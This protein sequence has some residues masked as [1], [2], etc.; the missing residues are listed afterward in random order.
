MIVLKFVN[1]GRQLADIFIKPLGRMRLQE[2]WAKISVIEI[3]SSMIR[4]LL[5]NL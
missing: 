2:L 4:E 3:K 1:S 5:D